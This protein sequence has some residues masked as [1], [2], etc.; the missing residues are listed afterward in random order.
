MVT[1]DLLGAFLIVI[2]LGLFL[3]GLSEIIPDLFIVSQY[4]TTVVRKLKTA[5]M[6]W[7]LNFIFAAWLILGTY[8]MWAFVI[9]HFATAIQVCV[10]FYFSL[11]KTK[12]KSSSVNKPGKQEQIEMTK[13]DSSNSSDSEKGYQPQVVVQSTEKVNEISYSEKSGS[14]S[15]SQPELSQD[16]SRSQY[17]SGSSSESE[18]NQEPQESGSSGSSSNENEQSGGAAEEYSEQTS[19]SSGEDASVESTSSSS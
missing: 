4:S 17:D 7:C 14:A 16:E 13:Q 19:G 15:S 11:V 5:K 3:F 8:C 12:T 2:G 10:S 6:S 9:V 1:F 18:S